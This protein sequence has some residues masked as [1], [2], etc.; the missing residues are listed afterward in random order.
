MDNIVTINNTK[1]NVLD[2]DISI[3]GLAT[4]DIRVWF[5]IKTGNMDIRF[6]CSK[7]ENDSWEVTIPPLPFIDKTAYSCSVSVVAD[8]YFFEPMVGTLNVTGSAE[9]YVKSSSNQT[10]KS[11]EADVIADEIKGAIK[12]SDLLAAAKRGEPTIQITPLADRPKTKM[13]ERGIAQVAKDMLAAKNATGDDGKNVK[14]PEKKKTEPK[15]DTDTGKFTAETKSN[16]K[17]NS[18]RAVLAELRAKPYQAKNSPLSEAEKL[19]DSILSESVK[20]RKKS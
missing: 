5:D 11:T 8:G 19:A 10:L 18:V 16:D 20:F 1:N 13:G 12:Q 17:S 4:E 6:E 14:K 7:K 15:K 9:V 3:Q 2:F